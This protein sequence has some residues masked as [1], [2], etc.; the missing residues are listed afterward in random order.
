MVKGFKFWKAKKN[1]EFWYVKTDSKI[2]GKILT[3]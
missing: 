3:N 1:K 2:E